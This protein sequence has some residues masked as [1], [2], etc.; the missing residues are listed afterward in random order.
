MRYETEAR[1]LKFHE[2]LPWSLSRKRKS[3]YWA[4]TPAVKLNFLTRWK[5]SAKT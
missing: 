2:L 3:V 5:Y 1:G 4:P